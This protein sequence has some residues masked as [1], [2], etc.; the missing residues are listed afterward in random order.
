M[1]PS[2]LVREGKQGAVKEVWSK[3]VADTYK[4]ELG[5]RGRGGGTGT[6]K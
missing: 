3:D 6:A 5:G 4:N 2:V 1:C